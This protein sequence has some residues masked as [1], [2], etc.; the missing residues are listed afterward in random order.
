MTRT[1]E[2]IIAS[3]WKRTMP[4][5]TPAPDDFVLWQWA[6]YPLDDVQYA[7]TRTSEKVAHNLKKN[8]P[9]TI[10]GAVRYASP[11]ILMRAQWR[12][13]RLKQQKEKETE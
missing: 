9:M 6:R 5:G 10:H 1:P 7:I 4:A 11:I 3:M 8:V 2:Q 12:A 13:E